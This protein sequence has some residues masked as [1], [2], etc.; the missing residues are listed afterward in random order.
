MPYLSSMTSLSTLIMPSACSSVKPSSF[1]R[2]TN[3]SVSKWW[4]FDCGTVAL[5]LRRNARAEA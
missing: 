2:C 3:L 4:S 5:K 1:I